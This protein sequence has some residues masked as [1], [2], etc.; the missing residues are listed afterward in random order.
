[1]CGAGR[2]PSMPQGAGQSIPVASCGADWERL[3]HQGGVEGGSATRQ[4][5]ARGQRYPRPRDFQ[6]HPRIQRWTPSHERML[7]ANSFHVQS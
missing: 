2:S 3:I 4:R 1:V 6:E 7:L 5:R